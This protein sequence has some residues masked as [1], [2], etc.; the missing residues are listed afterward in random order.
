MR[1]HYTLHALE[2]MHQRGIDRILV[3]KCLE[4]PD[5]DSLLGDTRK[6]IKKIDDRVL[7]VIYRKVNDTTLV[8]TAFISSKIHKYLA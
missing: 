6:C 2:R 3:E 4:N 1:I 8:I 7:V 5:K